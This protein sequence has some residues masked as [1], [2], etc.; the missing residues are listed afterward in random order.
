MTIFAFLPYSSSWFCLLPF[1]FPST[2]INEC[3]DPAP[4]A[5]CAENAECVNLPGHFACKC[6]SGFAGN[7]TDLCSGKKTIEWLMMTF[8]KFREIQ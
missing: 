1:H 8:E 3:E 4:G 5:L 2:D 6:K 7:A